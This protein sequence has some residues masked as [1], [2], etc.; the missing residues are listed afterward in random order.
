L[1]DGIPL[2]V[3]DPSLEAALELKNVKAFATKL[4]QVSYELKKLIN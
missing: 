2:I 4:L 3:K 1:G